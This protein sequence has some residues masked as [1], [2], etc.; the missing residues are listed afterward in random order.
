M[1]LHLFQNRK[2]KWNSPALTSPLSEFVFKGSAL[3]SSPSCVAPA[4]WRQRP[5]SH[6]SWLFTL[7][8]P[9]FSLLRPFLLQA[10]STA[11]P[12]SILRR[13]RSEGEEQFRTDTTYAWPHMWPYMQP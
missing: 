11:P 13:C 1:I 5:S 8:Q 7:F 2:K 9:L 6:P 4:A 3:S 10:S 12:D